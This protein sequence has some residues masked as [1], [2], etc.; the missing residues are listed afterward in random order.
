MSKMPISRYGFGLLAL[1][2]ALSVTSSSCE[3]EDFG[4]RGGCNRNTTTPTVVTDTTTTV[5]TDTTAT[6]SGQ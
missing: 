4:P 2:I 6:R 1:L 3:K 5:V